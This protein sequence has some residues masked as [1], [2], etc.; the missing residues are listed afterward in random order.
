ME[1]PA[2]VNA[3]RA[4]VE[5]ALTADEVRVL[6][7]WLEVAWQKLL[8][9]LPAIPARVE[10]DESHPAHL[11]VEIVKIAVVAMV[12][13]KLRNPDM[14]RSWNGDT[15]G[16]TI[17]SSASSGTIYVS[18]DELDLLAVRA[19]PGASGMYSIPLGRP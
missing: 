6:D 5:R 3:V 9:A 13:R 16:F 4:V 10:L 1:N 2:D 17:D 15:S 7:G 19:V 8:H 12:E 18:Q 11:S 14:L